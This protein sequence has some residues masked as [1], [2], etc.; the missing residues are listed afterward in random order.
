M[1]TT[2]RAAV[3]ETTGGEVRIG[4]YPAAPAQPGAVVVDVLHAGICGTDIHL[5]DGRLPVPLPVILGHEAVGVVRELGDGVDA[6]ATGD[7]LR[8]GDHVVWASS[9]PCGRCHY[10]VAL[11]EYSLCEQ[12]RVYGINQSAQ[13]WPHLSGGWAERIY[14]QPGTALFRVP[15]QLSGLE[16]VALGCAGPTIVHGL[17]G[18]AAPRVGEVVVIQGAGPVG[19][20]AAMYARLAGAGTIVLVGGPAERLKVAD[21][22]GVCDLALD[23][24]RHTEPEAR[25]DAARQVT[26]GRRG[27]DL[28]I[29]ATGLPSAV[30]EG[31]AMARR[32]GRYLVVGQYTDHGDTLINPHHITRKQLEVIG[33]WAF[34]AQHYERYVRTLPQ[35][36][37]HFDLVRLVTEYPL[38]QVNQAMSDMRAGTIIKPVLSPRL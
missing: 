6:D 37:D 24:D 19:M 32:G 10:C 13:V 2:V 20:A 35:V 34:S 26:P 1:V 7:R 12:R 4:T 15:A 17:L 23:I 22:L 16:V 5:Q 29:E 25:I 36:A 27:A 30:A 14:L 21:E 11:H 28:V 31:I 33:S 18:R 3:L 8:A 38:A 9:I